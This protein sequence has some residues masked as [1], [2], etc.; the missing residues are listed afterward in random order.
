MRVCQKFDE[1]QLVP[2]TELH[3]I[4]KPWPSWGWGLDFIGVGYGN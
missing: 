1:L 3:H 2:A 4:I